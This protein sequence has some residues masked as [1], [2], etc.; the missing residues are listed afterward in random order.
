M[1]RSTVLQS[2]FSIS[3]ISKPLLDRFL[4]YVKIHTTSDEDA[5]EDKKPSSD[6]Q[7]DLARLLVD[8]L[9]E[10]GV[11]DVNIDEHACVLARIPASPGYE[12]C[13]SIIFNSHIDT[14]SA[15][16]GENV[17]PQIHENYDGG[18][19]KVGNG[20]FLDPAMN[21]SLLSAKGDTII[22]ADGTTLLGA[23]DK[24]GIAE[25]MT[26]LDVVLNHEKIP[27]GP[28]EVMFNADEEI[29][30]G[31][32][33]FP[34]DK[35]K[36]KIG[37]TVDG[38]T[39]GSYEHVNF[40]AYTV[41]AKFTGISA[42]TGYARGKMVNAVS[43]ASSFINMLPKVESPEATD[44][45]YG[46]YCPISVKGEFETAE[47]IV[48]LRDFSMDGM[49]RRINACYEFGKAIEAMYPGG[50]VEIVPKYGYSNMDDKLKDHPEIILN[51][52][53]AMQR[54]GI[55][56]RDTLIRGGTDGSTMTTQYDIMTPN[57][58]TGSDNFH[59]KYEWAAHGQ[60]IGCVQVLIELV[61][62][63]AGN[64]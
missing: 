57:I 26:M 25:I 46:F 44:G 23:D 55:N 51:V 30:R 64:K 18:V 24:C 49:N 42:H 40:N 6:R 28:F 47:A 60:M 14:S 34:A 17:K 29:G 21:P 58:F 16:S 31:T 41:V 56:P 11:E 1:D 10:I 2:R 12:S 13:Q 37:F 9:K 35:V 63:Y 15:C 45:K 19:I 7:F 61:K 39:E 54:V 32:L 20:V 4:R 5:A 50:R 27:H 36:S 3:Y 8:E 22:T 53:T 33:Y 43:M 38:D 62:I 48:L 59:S 52:V